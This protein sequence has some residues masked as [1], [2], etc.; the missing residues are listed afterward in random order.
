MPDRNANKAIIWSKILNLIQRSNSSAEEN[1]V[2]SCL[3]RF[4]RIS[5]RKIDSKENNEIK[6][7]NTKIGVENFI[8]MIAWPWLNDI[9]CV[10]VKVKFTNSVF[11]NEQ[12]STR[13]TQNLSFFFILALSIFSAASS[14]VRDFIGSLKKNLKGLDE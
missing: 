5:K 2:R 8:F 3:E 7:E 9:D 10:S 12:L 14:S 6:I 13:W 11:L 4:E 1:G